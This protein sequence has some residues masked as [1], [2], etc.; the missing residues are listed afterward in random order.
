MNFIV[1]YNKFIKYVFSFECLCFLCD[2][3][4]DCIIFL[5]ILLVIF[6]EVFKLYFGVFFIFSIIFGCFKENFFKVV[7]VNE[8]FWGYIDL[9]FVFFVE[10]R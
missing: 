3:Y 4:K 5:N 7:I 9:V 8:I 10:F 2:L 6:F 1:F